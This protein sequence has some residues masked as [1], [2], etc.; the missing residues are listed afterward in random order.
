MKR[1][2]MHHHI[3]PEQYVK[4]LASI[5]ITESYGQSFPEWS[6]EKS[7][8]F[9][10]KVGI[11]VAVMSISTPGV[12]F[13]D[14]HFSRDLARSCNEKMAEVKRNYPGRF[15]GFAA[16]PLPDVAAALEE[17]RYGLDE[18]G[19]DGVCLF[20]HYGGKYLGDKD[21]EDF[22]GELNQ[23][24]T[25]V[26]I[27]PTDP[28]GQ[29]DPGLGM[30]NSLIEAP[31]ETTRAVANMLFT[32][33]MDRYSEIKFILSHGGGTI[34]YLAWRLALIEYGQKD[35]PPP[36][37]CK[38]IYDFLIKGGPV[39]GLKILK[40]MYYDTALTTSP[41]ALRAL[42][43]LA[44]SG[45]IVFGTDYPFGAKFAPMLAKDLRRYPGFSEQDMRSIDYGNGRE[46]FPALELR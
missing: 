42:Q 22:F 12:S 9:M 15:G 1:I 45:H 33:S 31:F 21:F 3:V 35:K 40:D 7:L 23:R 28:M 27:H 11:D 46:I 38:S 26:F 13:A 30:R 6:P 18:L 20:T 32:G 10:S 41:A 44:G 39:S 25:V 8:S 34:P 29:Y 2:D 37:F 43:E 4:G 19:L 14:V 36:V 17:L 16:V 5:G 24:K